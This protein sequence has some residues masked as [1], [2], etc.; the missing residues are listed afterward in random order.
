MV[1][2]ENGAPRLS[3]GL[4]HLHLFFFPMKGC[5]SHAKTALHLLMPKAILPHPHPGLFPSGLNYTGFL[6][7]SGMQGREQK[8]K[9][10][11]LSKLQSKDQ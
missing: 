2:N 4:L 11:E 9:R 1:W 8:W 5:G 6:K 7:S 3:L 10:H